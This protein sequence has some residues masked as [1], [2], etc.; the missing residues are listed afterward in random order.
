MK[1]RIL[2]ALFSILVLSVSI[3]C[4]LPKQSHANVLNDLTYEIT[5]G[6]VTIFR[7]RNSASGELVIPDTIEGYPVT[8]IRTNAFVDCTKLTS[9][10]IP[11]SVTSIGSGA[12]E[13]CTG[14][15]SITIPDGVT[16]IGWQA[17]KGCSSLTS[18]TIPEGV[19]SIEN[20]TFM[21]CT[22]LASITIPGGVSN[23]G[24]DAFYHC[25]SLTDVYI[26]N[27][28]IVEQLTHSTAQGCLVEHA[29]TIKIKSTISNIPDYIKSTYPDMTLMTVDGVS[30]KVY[31]KVVH[32]HTDLDVWV[33]NSVAHWHRCGLCGQSL[34]TMPHSFG[35][36]VTTKEPTA[37]EEGSKT[38][39]C[40]VCNREKTEAIPAIGVTPDTKP[41]TP[42]DTEPT[43]EP[44]QP[45]TTQP[46]TP[47]GDTEQPNTVLIAAVIVL[48]C[49][50]IGTAV[51]I[52][53]LK[54][55]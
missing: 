45:A 39:V 13:G 50:A 52:L 42:P 44:T 49:L 12:F 4:M 29:E 2:V 38:C 51:V 34:D 36:W 32:E 27:P 11:E 16:S 26:Q 18:V 21:D 35:D 37:T 9:I 25:N 46:T 43:D 47:A 48:A 40:S 14:L 1:K 24:Y 30:Y 22:S 23:I 33:T 31:G 3:L 53:V 7:C 5:D 41:T 15:T 8:T 28:S 19:T 10:T 17:F 20:S 55:K 54:K 6:A